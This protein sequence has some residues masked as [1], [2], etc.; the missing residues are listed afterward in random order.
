MDKRPRIRFAV[1]YTN[2]TMSRSFN[3]LNKLV[4]K[5]AYPGAGMDG[6]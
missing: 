4:A 2:G 5:I 3:R 1:I 6:R